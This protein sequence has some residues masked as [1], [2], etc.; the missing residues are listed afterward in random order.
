VG[1]V[2]EPAEPRPTY[3]FRQLTE[4]DRLHVDAMCSLYTIELGGEAYYLALADRVDDERVA[5][6]L[7]RNGRE[8]AGHA[9]RLGRAIAHVQGAPFTPS[10]EMR[11]VRPVQLADDLV[12]DATMLS[13]LVQGEAEGDR[14]YERWAEHE[15]DPEVAKL[16]RRNG[17]EEALHGRRVEQAIALLAT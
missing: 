15:P 1:A 11:E 3:S 4:L 2:T 17:R 12:I 5:T 9:R 8:E 14:I 10:P 13:R 7:R 6:L 16:L